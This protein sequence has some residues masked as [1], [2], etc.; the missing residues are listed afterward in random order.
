MLHVLCLQVLQATLQAGFL[1]RISNDLNVSICDQFFLGGPLSLRG[2]NTRGV[3]PHR[4]GNALGASVSN[5]CT[6]EMMNLIL[7]RDLSFIGSWFDMVLVCESC[8]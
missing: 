6:A 5:G 7:I 2:F 8:P 4:D 3:G 1:T